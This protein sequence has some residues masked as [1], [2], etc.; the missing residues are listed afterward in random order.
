MEYKKI[1]NLLDNTLNEPPKF[2]AK[3][4]VEVNDDSRGMCSVDSQIK[5]KTSMLRSNL[6]DYNDAYVLVKRTITVPNTAAADTIPDNRNKKVI[7]K[8]CALFSDCISAIN[9]AET[10]YVKDIDVGM[11]IYNLI[12]YS[13]N[14]L[15]TSANLWQYYRDETALNG[16]NCMIDFLDVDGNSASFRFKQKVTG[17][18]RNNGTKYVQRT[19]PLEYIIIF[20]ELLKCR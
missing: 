16:H 1:I 14:Y 6:C 15:K 2:R 18:T 9:D 13:N 19:L 20:G 8:N 5:F 12:E 4:Y 10:D 7:F 3:N 11:L 17:Q